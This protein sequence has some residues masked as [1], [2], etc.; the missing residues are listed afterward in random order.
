MKLVFLTSWVRIILENILNR[1]AAALNLLIIGNQRLIHFSYLQVK[2]ILVS[3]RADLLFINEAK[4]GNEALDGSFLHK[5]YT[6]LRNDCK[7]FWRDVMFFVM[8]H[9]SC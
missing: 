7:S 5:D 1:K 6:I 2:A 9:R 4:L 3:S 8:N